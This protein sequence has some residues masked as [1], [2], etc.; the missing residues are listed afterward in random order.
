MARDA[1]ETGGLSFNPDRVVEQVR[2]SHALGGRQD[3]DAV[4]SYRPLGRPDPEFTPIGLDDGEFLIDTSIRYVIARYDQQFPTVAFDGTNFLVVWEDGRS[5]DYDIY[6][7]RV[8]PAGKVLDPAGFVIS[9]A[10]NRQWYPALAFDGTNFLVVWEDRRSGDY[11]IYGARVTPGGVVLDPSGFV[12]S[13]AANDQL[14]PALGFDGA[15]FLVVWEDRRTSDYGIYGARVTPA[16]VVLDSS[17]FVVSQA[18]NDQENPA[19]GFDG[20]DFLVVWQDYRSGSDGDIYG[21]RVTP[22]GVVLDSSGFVVSQA[23]ND[24]ENPALGF[25]GADF[26]VVWE[27]HRTSNYGVYGARVTPGGVVLDSTGFVISQAANFQGTPALDFDGADFLVVWQDT[28]SNYYGIYGSRVTPAGVVLDSSG[29]VISQGGHSQGAPVPGFDGA[30]FLVVWEDCRNGDYDIYSARVT[31]AGLVLDSSGILTSQ[32]AND[33][34]TPALGFDGA[35]FLVAWQDSCGSYSYVCGAR[36]TAAGV[37]LDSSSFVISHTTHSLQF[38]AIAFDGANFLVVWQD[39]DGNYTG[40]HGAR[41]TPA[42]VV[43]DPS[44]FVITRTAEYQAIPALGFDGAN[45]LVVWEDYRSDGYRVC[46]AR[47]TPAGAVLDSSG[48][49]ISQTADF[50]EAPALGFDGANFLVVWE[51]YRNGSDYDIY[52]ARVTPAGKVLDSS[53]FV[54]SQAADNQWSPALGLDGAN[55]LVVWEDYRSGSDYCIYGARVTPAGVVLDS[56]GFVIFQTAEPDAAPTLGF[57]GADFLV[58]WEDYRSGSNHDIYGA[59]VTP[60]GEVFD[61]GPVVQQDGEQ[62]YPKLACGAGNQLF[63]VYQGWAG[64]VGGETYNADRIWVKLV[65]FEGVEERTTPEA[66]RITPIPTIV[67]GVLEIGPQLTANGSQPKTELLDIG[68]RKVLALHPGPND[69]SRLGAGVY[70]VRSEPSAVSREP[71][72]VHKVILTR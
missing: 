23:E 63:L 9:H 16:G 32:A 10:A 65:P 11:D 18:E 22:A 42:G 33:Q 35:N 14:F 58:V 53:G 44:G 19:L 36:V 6:G 48:F 34:W 54:I 46:G 68:G 30:N 49:V 3:G 69:V 70:F 31:S 12:V 43:L 56:S 21:A 50:Q 15:N 67:R 7:V 1:G 27:D 52:G 4:H 64:T 38:P 29:F 71:S 40:I 57:E 5:G 8:T 47:V 20:A 72:A 66:G 51:D 17:G 2:T 13:Q 62:R 24:Q 55:F 61:S 60:Q 41:V 26:L 45:F 39:F 37:V 59:R 28:R 25:D